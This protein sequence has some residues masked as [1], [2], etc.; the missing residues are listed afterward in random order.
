MRLITM[1][2]TQIARLFGQ[3]HVRVCVR[4]HNYRLDIMCVCVLESVLMKKNV[5]CV[6]IKCLCVH[7]QTLR[8]VCVC[9]VYYSPCARLAASETQFLVQCVCPVLNRSSVCGVST[10]RHLFWLYIY[11][12]LFTKC[13][14]LH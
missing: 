3:P 2:S 14:W 1:C 11:Y 7:A 6:G 13:T 5:V 4:M 12:N 9:V 10:V 8:H